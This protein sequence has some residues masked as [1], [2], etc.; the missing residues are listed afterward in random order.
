M[1]ARSTQVWVIKLACLHGQQVYASC[2]V[3]IPPFRG[4]SRPTHTCYPSYSALHTDTLQA[5]GYI[6][7]KALLA[8]AGWQ[9]ARVDGALDRGD[10]Q[11]GPGYGG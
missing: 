5:P 6:S 3:G 4:A 1:S 8:K 10:A 7:L 2:P 9:P 11:A